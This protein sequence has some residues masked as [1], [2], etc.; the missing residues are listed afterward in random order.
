ML[1]RLS[2][3]YRLFVLSSS[4]RLDIF[5]VYSPELSASAALYERICA[6]GLFNSGQT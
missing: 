3:N 5:R 6:G 4:S 2:Q 1:H